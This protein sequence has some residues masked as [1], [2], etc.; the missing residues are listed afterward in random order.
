[1]NPFE[2]LG[3]EKAASFDEIKK[4]FYQLA[5]H[6]HPDTANDESE[7][8]EKQEKFAQITQAYN[9]LKNNSTFQY[10]DNTK[11]EDS[12]SENILN[13]AKKLMSVKDFNSA[14]NILMSIK[15]YKMGEVEKLLGECYLK[16][17][18]FH[19]ALK[20]FKAAYDMNQ[21]DTAIRFKMGFI[22]EKIGLKNSARKI[23]QE[24]LSIEPSNK[25]ALEHL[26]KLEKDGFSLSSFFKGKL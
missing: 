5:R 22:Y 14:I 18:R 11:Y 17:E 20:H 7:L 24:I 25:N 15:D 16:K 9:M 19:D 12:Y 26:S 8:I 2:V 21:W 3:L 4:R 1:M 6:L 13:K 23:Y 10:K